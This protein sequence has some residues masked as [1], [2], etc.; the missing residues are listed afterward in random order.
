METGPSWARDVTISVS[1]TNL[2]DETPPIVLNGTFSWDS[3]A[4][5]SI[6]R[7]LAVE[8]SKRW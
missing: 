2:F 3:Q 5:S 8:V 6:G 7:L 4:A 1:A